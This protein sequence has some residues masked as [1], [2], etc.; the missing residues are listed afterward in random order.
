[1]L[2][3]LTDPTNYRCIFQLSCNLYFQASYLFGYPFLIL[4]MLRIIYY[5]LQRLVY[6]EITMVVD[7]FPSSYLSR[8][9]QKQNCAMLESTRTITSLCR[10]Y[11]S[12]R[13][14]YLLS[15]RYE[16]LSTT[17]SNYG[18]P[19]R[20]IPRL[21]AWSVRLPCWTSSTAKQNCILPSRPSRI[22]LTHLTFIAF[23]RALFVFI[24]ES[25]WNASMF[26]IGTSVFYA[27]TCRARNRYRD[28]KHASVLFEILSIVGKLV[29]YC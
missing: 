4:S 6:R 10:V 17:E 28:T 14:Y 2:E 20:F 21:A 3:R 12:C 19:V 1:M 23:K 22:L 26:L 24:G 9:A 5:N 27:R 15:N 8:E 29:G 18:R 16:A 25:E 13:A 11:T 7:S